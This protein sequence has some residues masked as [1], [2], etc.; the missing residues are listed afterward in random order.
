MLIEH[1]TV[2]PEQ[3]SRMPSHLYSR[4]RFKQATAKRCVVTV[5]SVSSSASLNDRSPVRAMLPE[6]DR[7]HRALPPLL[8]HGISRLVRGFAPGQAK[9]KGLFRLFQTPCATAG[10]AMRRLQATAEK[11]A[12]PNLCI[13]AHT[14]EESGLGM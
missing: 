11:T 4:I 13:A 6:D 10:E 9:E 12:S 3:T 5:S 8:Q 7:R 14:G 2:C 1:R